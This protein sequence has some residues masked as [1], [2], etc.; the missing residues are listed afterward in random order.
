MQAHC[1]A[2]AAAPMDGMMGK[3]DQVQLRTRDHAQLPRRDRRGRAISG[4]VQAKKVAD[5]LVGHQFGQKCS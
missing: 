3:T 4:H 2:T 5:L 1:T